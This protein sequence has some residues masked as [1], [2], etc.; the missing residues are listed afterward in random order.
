MK[1]KYNSP[2]VKNKR[3]KLRYQMTIPEIFLW[4]KIRNKQLGY[5]F[6]RQYSISSFIVDFYCPEFPP[7]ADQPLAERLACLPVLRSS[8]LLLRRMDAQP[9]RSPTCQSHFGD[10]TRRQVI[11]LDGSQHLE[12][13]NIIY[14][15]KRT[16]YFNSSII[17]NS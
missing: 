14:D 8:R 12:I 6:R 3:R 9:L 11:E 10:G 1:F 15:K 4:S 2:K 16:K 5:K 17:L 13:K 7:E